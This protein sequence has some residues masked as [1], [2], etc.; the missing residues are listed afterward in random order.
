MADGMR[1]LTC[2]NATMAQ[3]TEKLR[4]AA[5]AYFDHLIVDMTGLKGGYDF[6][7]SWAPRQ[8]T[9][10]A[11]PRADG[12][13]EATSTPSD[14]SNDLTVFE[15]VEKQ[16]GLKLSKQQQPAMVLVI[17]KLERVPTEN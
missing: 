1:N 13:P 14:P 16:L 12:A 6:V 5:P 7:V 3:F 2:Q 4:E 8:R 10:V 17:D 11:P 9:R 15:A